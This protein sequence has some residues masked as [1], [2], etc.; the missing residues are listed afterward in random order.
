MDD[1]GQP[2]KGAPLRDACLNLFGSIIVRIG[3]VPCKHITAQALAVDTLYINPTQ[4]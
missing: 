2:W 4:F 1:E 3:G